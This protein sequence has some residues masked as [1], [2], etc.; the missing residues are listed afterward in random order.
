[1][2]KNLLKYSRGF[3]CLHDQ[4]FIAMFSFSA[5]RGVME[6]QLVTER[7]SD[8]SVYVRDIYLKSRENSLFPSN[9]RPHPPLRHGSGSPHLINTPQLSQR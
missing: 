4:L 5:I 6:T 8:N 3:R 2:H 7:R 9:V 1:M